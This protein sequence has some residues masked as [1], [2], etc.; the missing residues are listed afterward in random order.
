[1]RS[2]TC[3]GNVPAPWCL[4]WP[5]W[6]WQW[7]SALPASWPGPRASPSARADHRVYRDHP[8]HAVPGADLLPVLRPAPARPAAEPDH[9]GDHRALGLNGGAYAIEN[10]R[11]GVQSIPHGQIEAALALG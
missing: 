3:C 4:P 1:M 8:Q 5:T 9:D 6:R 11:G 2:R 10:I 7:S